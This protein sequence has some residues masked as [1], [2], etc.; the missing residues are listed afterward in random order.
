[1]ASPGPTLPTAPVPA[2][3]ESFETDRLIV[4]AP[5]WDDGAAVNAAILESLPEL[6]AWMGWARPAPPLEE[7]E[8]N[9][10]RARLRYLRRL[11][12]RLHLFHKETGR[13]LG[14]SGLHR[15]DW[16]LRRF[17]IGYWLRTSETGHGYMTEAVAGIAAFAARELGANRI[18]IRCDARN[19]RSRRVAERLGFR[20]EGVLRGE[21]LD[22]EGLPADEMI[23][24][25]VRGHEF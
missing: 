23:F 13:F 3:P 14:S 24:A 1:M 17:E 8:A 20:L 5:G 9:V 22:A 11:D 21:A 4:R 16:A 18:E 2:V 6:Q 19:A 7:T 15:I 12:L 10:Q 25:R